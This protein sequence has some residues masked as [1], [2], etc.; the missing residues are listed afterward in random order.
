M[1]LPEG[2]SNLNYSDGTETG[3]SV[4]KIPRAFARRGGNF[5]LPS[6]R[7]I[8]VQIQRGSQFLLFVGKTTHVFARGVGNFE[9][10]WWKKKRVVQ[11]VGNYVLLVSKNTH[12]F[13]RGAGN[14]ELFWWTKKCVFQ[15]WSQICFARLR[16]YLP[17]RVAILN[18]SG[19][20]RNVVFRGVESLFSLLTRMRIYLPERGSN[21]E[22]FWWKKQHVFQRVGKFVFFVNKT[23]HVFGG[24]GGNFEWFWWKKERVV[25]GWKLCF[26]GWQ[27]Y[28]CICQRGWQFR[29]VLAEKETCCSE[30][31][32]LC[33]AS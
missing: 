28:A 18:C 12:V 1:Y 21:F 23:T 2:G 13:A 27:A 11:R 33:L 22:L 10:F 31:L 6:S 3:C 4:N 30:G 17:E 24:R 14:F 26:A 19:G 7:D 20:Q 5:E 16:M 9:W 15:R 32:Q 25:E 29:M 8:V